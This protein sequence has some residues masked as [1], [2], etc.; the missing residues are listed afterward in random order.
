MISLHIVQISINWTKD[1]SFYTKLRY[2]DKYAYETQMI[3]ISD[4]LSSVSYTH[5]RAHETPEHLV[6]R[7]LLEKKLEA[8][9]VFFYAENLDFGSILSTLNHLLQ[10]GKF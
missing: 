5:L 8:L 7:L 1:S 3:T 6:C 4:T 9:F 2:S 10:Q